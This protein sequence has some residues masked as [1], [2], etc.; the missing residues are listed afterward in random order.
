MYIK[1]MFDTA[2]FSCDMDVK[3]YS[4][5]PFHLVCYNVQTFYRDEIPY[6]KNR[7]IILIQEKKVINII[8]YLLLS[9]IIY[10]FVYN[11]SYFS[12]S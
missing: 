3:L 4:V 9:Y 10:S 2:R 7:S 12:I 6:V 1:K 8:T 11:E 5:F